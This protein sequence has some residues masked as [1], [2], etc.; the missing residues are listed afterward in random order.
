METT[1]QSSSFAGEL[2]SRKVIETDYGIPTETQ[3]VW[4]TNDRYGWR[5]LS[6]KIGASVRYKRSEV[7]AW[8]ESRRQA[9]LE[10]N[11]G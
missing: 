7:E 3:E 9:K 4:H 2:I 6:Y 11:H 8:I 1:D 5:D 10:A